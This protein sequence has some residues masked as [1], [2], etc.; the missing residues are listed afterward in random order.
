MQS[1]EALAAREGKWWMIAVPEI[2]GLTQARRRSEV[3]LMARELIAI[4]VDIPVDDVHVDV[5]FA[6]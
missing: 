6:R 1:Y 2:G 4:T 3:E 5:E